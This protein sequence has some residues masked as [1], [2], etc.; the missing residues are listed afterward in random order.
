[1]G[2]RKFECPVKDQPEQQKA[3]KLSA[4]QNQ[5]ASSGSRTSA[6]AKDH[7]QGGKPKPAGV[8]T[9]AGLE[10]SLM[11]KAIVG[12][13]QQDCLVDTGATVSLINPEQVPEL[14]LVISN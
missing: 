14:C 5:G 1:M 3:A 12:G 9:V 4:R 13:T 11:L 10:S 7:V 2:H 6:G 8:Y